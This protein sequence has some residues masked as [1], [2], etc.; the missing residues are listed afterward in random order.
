MAHSH[1]SDEDLR[2]QRAWATALGQA[3]SGGSDTLLVETP[4]LGGQPR[5]DFLGLLYIYHTLGG[6][7]NRDLFFHGLGGSKSKIKL[8]VG[9][10]PSGGSEGEPFRASSPSSW[11]RLEVLGIPWLVVAQLQSLLYLHLASS[12]ELCVFSLSAP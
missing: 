10:A 2:A 9:L 7:N 5:C 4:L 12:P 3:H 6:L 8:C 1:L 11:A